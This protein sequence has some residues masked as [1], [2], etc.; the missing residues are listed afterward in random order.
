VE[1]DWA[2]VA[3]LA[4]EHSW[5]RPSFGLH[6]W[7][8]KE[9]SANWKAALIDSIE[10]VGERVAVG[11]I[12][13]DRWIEN[14]DLDDQREVF[15]WQLTLAA[16][17]NLPATI[18]CLQAWGALAEVLRAEPVPE[19][20]F[21]IHAYGGPIEMLQEFAD[22]GAYFSF[23]GAHLHARK[24]ARREVFQVVPLERLLVETDA[25]AMPPPPE[26]SPYSLPNTD[27]D[28][29]VNHPANIAHI[30]EELAKLRGMSLESLATQVEENFERL[31]GR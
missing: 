27:D 28:Q 13:L 22:R 8:I 18:H 11:E 7:R 10:S 26:H 19:C 2:E 23:N 4:K 16:E 5:I 15:V 21:L 6:P 25:P 29:T 3:K 12:G 20:G 14:Y 30:Y 31:F 24:T 9:R 1:N 17:R